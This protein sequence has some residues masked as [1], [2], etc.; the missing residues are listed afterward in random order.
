MIGGIGRIGGIGGIGR[1]G[2]IGGGMIGAGGPRFDAEKD[3]RA[4]LAAPQPPITPSSS[5]L[6][7]RW[8][9]FDAHRDSEGASARSRS[10]SDGN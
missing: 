8:A 6:E 1:I 4:L 3:Y 5:P 7:V 2:G 9:P 10:A